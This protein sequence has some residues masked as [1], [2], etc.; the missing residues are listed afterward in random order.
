[1]MVKV[2]MFGSA[3]ELTGGEPVEIELPESASVGELK[4]ALSQAFPQ[5]A[6][7]V[8][9]SAVSVDQQYALD[10]TKLG[11]NLEVALIPP[12]SGG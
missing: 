9:R 6:E 7:L 11:P 3:K 10:D 5:L 12:V 8:S 2:K 1:M 4:R